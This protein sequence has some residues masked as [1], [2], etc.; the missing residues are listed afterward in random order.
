MC[1][2]I[3][4][5]CKIV[6]LYGYGIEIVDWVFLLIEMIDYNFVYLVIKV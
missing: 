6:G 4:N 5:F 1:L 3:N 2:I